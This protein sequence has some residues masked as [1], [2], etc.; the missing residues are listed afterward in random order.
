MWT[1]LKHMDLDILFPLGAHCINVLHK[2]CVCSPEGEHMK[3]FKKKT[4]TTFE[5]AQNN[6]TNH[7]SHKAI[8]SLNQD[9]GNSNAL[10]HKVTSFVV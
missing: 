10:K 2:Q 8:F 7:T 3:D 6:P 4:S 1:F 9:V 5:N